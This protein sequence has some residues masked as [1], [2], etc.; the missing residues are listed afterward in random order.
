M[1]YKR[2]SIFIL[3]II[4]SYGWFD[5]NK[6]E[7]GETSYCEIKSMRPFLLEGRHF[8]VVFL[9]GGQHSCLLSFVLWLKHF[10]NFP[11]KNGMEMRKHR[12]IGQEM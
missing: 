1:H 4:V 2:V 3:L 6:K 7:K 5:Q 12:R 9:V 10:T 8:W 11:Q